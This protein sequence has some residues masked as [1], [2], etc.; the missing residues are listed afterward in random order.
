MRIGKFPGACYDFSDGVKEAASS[1]LAYFGYISPILLG[2]VNQ[3]GVVFHVYQPNHLISINVYSLQMPIPLNDGAC[4]GLNIIYLMS[5]IVQKLFPSLCQSLLLL[6][7]FS[8]IMAK[9]QHPDG[10]GICLSLVLR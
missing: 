3:P 8:L 6:S 2:I 9:L 4:T 10:P 7:H 1:L 5:C